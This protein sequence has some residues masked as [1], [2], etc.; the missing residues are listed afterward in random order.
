MNKK[1]AIEILNRI[2]QNQMVLHDLLRMERWWRTLGHHTKEAIESHE[3]QKGY[4]KKIT[5]DKLLLL[6]NLKG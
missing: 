5:E 1:E 4:D 3:I 2:I 6:E